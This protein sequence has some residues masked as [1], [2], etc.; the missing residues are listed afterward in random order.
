MATGGGGMGALLR[1]PMRSRVMV[2]WAFVGTPLRIELRSSRYFCQ[3]GNFL[4][5]VSLGS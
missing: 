4:L 2:S 5:H 3:W 1:S